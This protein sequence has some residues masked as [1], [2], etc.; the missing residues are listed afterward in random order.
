MRVIAV[1]SLDR[2]GEQLYL[3]NNAEWAVQAF[4]TNDMHD[5]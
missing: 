4:L 5:A 2:H 1:R 3:W